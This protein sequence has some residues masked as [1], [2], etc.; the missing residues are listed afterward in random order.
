MG[1]FCTSPFLQHHHRRRRDHPHSLPSFLLPQHVYTE[2]RALHRAR[3]R[4]LLRRPPP[5]HPRQ[6]GRGPQ[7]RPRGT[8]AQRRSGRRSRRR[9]STLESPA[10]SRA[11]SA[12]E[13]AAAKSSRTQKTPNSTSRSS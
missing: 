13:A 4:D 11:S 1:G 3:E 6:G 7:A 8:P 9:N 10:S 12:V 2:R 5:P